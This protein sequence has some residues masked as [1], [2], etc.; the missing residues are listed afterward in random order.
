MATELRAKI[1]AK[2]HENRPSISTSSRKTYTSLLSSL[3]KILDIT[4]LS[5]FES[6][7]EDIMDTLSR[8]P[9]VSRATI[10]AALFVLTQRDDL[11]RDQMIQDAEQNKKAS[12]DQRKTPKQ[13]AV[14]ALITKEEFD[15]VVVDLRNQLTQMLKGKA[16]LNYRVAN[17]AL[18][19]M[20]MTCMPPRRSLDYCICKIKDYDASVD[21]YYDAKKKL[22][23]MNQYK[24]KK[25]L[26]VQTVD[27]KP[28]KTEADLLTKWVKL[29]P[30][31]W[32][33][34]TNKGTHLTPSGLNKLLQQFLPQGASTNYI[35]HQFARKLYGQIDLNA[36][37][38]TAT[39]MGHS[40]MT[41]IST[42][43]NFK[44]ASAA[45]G[46]EDD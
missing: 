13:E 40:M 7:H 26:G 37:Q 43:N 38:Q 39:A 21:N 36:L 6:R 11:Y 28:Y 8:R 3:A 9:A 19:L 32:L 23:V 35:R 46:D 18:F 30:T 29:N 1:D 24:T 44:P 34:P 15:A 20:L 25:H 5:E 22:F 14:E 42:Y 2:L 41:G 27:M 31:E 45:M 33:L 10:L 16:M 4:K 12:T 17:A